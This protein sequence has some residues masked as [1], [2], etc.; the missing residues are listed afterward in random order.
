MWIGFLLSLQSYLAELEPLLTGQYSELM[1]NR[2]LL[3]N[4]FVL[5]LG[6]VWKA[7]DGTRDGNQ[8]QFIIQMKRCFFFC[9]LAGCNRAPKEP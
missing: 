1:S 7:V 2:R 5:W 3:K 9:P 6:A 4:R 8:L